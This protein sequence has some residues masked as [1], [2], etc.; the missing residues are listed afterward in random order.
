MKRIEHKILHS[1]EGNSDKVYEVDLCEVSENNYLV[2]FRFGRRGATLKEGTKTTSPVNYTQAQKLFNELVSSKTKKGYAEVSETPTEEVKKIVRLTAPK[3]EEDAPKKQAVLER[4]AHKKGNWKLSRAI[5]KAGQLKIKEAED[6]II[7]HLVDKNEMQKYA[8]IWA[9]GFCGSEKSI[10]ELEKIIHGESTEPT[11]LLNIFLP[12]EK[13]S[14]LLKRI[15]QEALLKLY[16]ENKIEEVKNNLIENLPDALKNPL[17]QNHLE[18]FKNAVNNYLSSNEY[19]K[20]YVLYDLYLIDNDL[21]R[22]VIIEL[23]KTAPFKSNYF[24]QLRHIFKAAEYRRDAEVFGLLAYRFEKEKA[25]FRSVESDWLSIDIDKLNLDNETKNKL[26]QEHKKNYVNWGNY[27]YIYFKDIKKELKT[28]K[29]RFVFSNLTKDYFRKRVTRTLRE[30]G[31]NND[32]D[33]VKMAVGVLLPYKDSDK[34]EI[35]ISIKNIVDWQT[36]YKSNYKEYKCAIKGSV[37][38]SFSKYLALN[39]VLHTNSNKYKLKKSGD[40]WVVNLPNTLN[41]TS[42]PVFEKEINDF[43]NSDDYKNSDLNNR[44]EA[45][46]ELWNQNPAGLI[47]LLIESECEIVHEFASKALFENKAIWNEIDTEVLLLILNKKYEST[48][49]VGF[50]IA[51][52]L[53]KANEDDDIVVALACCAYQPARKQAFLWLANKREKFKKDLDFILAFLTSDFAD[54]RE[55]GK[56]LTA[57]SIMDDIQAKDFIAKVISHLFLLKED[58]IE[59]VRDLTDALTY[60]FPYELEEVGLNIIEDL[61]S[62]KML[63]IQQFGCY[64]IIRTKVKPENIPQELINLIINSD[65]EY[66]R[67][68][69]SKIIAKLPEETLILKQELFLAFLTNKLPDIRKSIVPLLIKLLTYKVVSEYCDRS[70]LELGRETYTYTDIDPNSDSKKPSVRNKFFGEEI[71]KSLFIF[72]KTKN[73]DRELLK[74]ICNLIEKQLVN[75]HYCLDKDFILN[76]LESKNLETQTLCGEILQKNLAWAKELELFELVKL[77]NHEVKAIRKASWQMILFIKDEI[78]AKKENM[79]KI[80]RFFDSK[81]EDTREF[82]CKEFSKTFNNDSWTAEF[83]ISLCDSIYE[84]IRFF[85]RNSIMTYFKQQDGQTYLIKLSEHPSK[86][87][88]LFATNYLETYASDNIERLL[89]LKPYF[90]RVL[91]NVNRSRTAKNRILEFLKKESLKNQAS[92]ELVSEILSWYSATFAVGDKAQSIETLLFLQE[93]YQNIT[94]SVKIKEPEVKNAV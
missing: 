72:L 90:K 32:P 65:Y 20:F 94:S 77:S 64:L 27:T 51:Q 39:F 83:L 11:S 7:A 12:K 89:E 3:L 30:L 22:P 52:E 68:F 21:C 82:A 56:N 62:H 47:H 41:K 84:D 87:I 15:A 35:R 63:K 81:K 4:L 86:D 37:Y 43:L 80:V 14:T 69:A 18:L 74:D 44:N 66:V 38:D 8:C 36:Y 70:D 19:E 75:L 5:Y 46:P 92:A 40:F 23:I 61:L 1:S 71:L 10:I 49:K 57:I 59:K 53:Y 50:E 13:P 78:F 31:E 29:S 58:E 25:V 79:S 45:F 73:S 28:E 91:S 34:D 6:L 2:N 93:K 60:R 26:K 88:Q 67:E 54:T 55:Q 48:L 42:I 16:D 24:K 9:L 76:I 33:Y 17:K 85:A